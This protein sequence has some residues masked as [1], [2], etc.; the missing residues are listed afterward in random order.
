M[1][2]NVKL[3][4]IVLSTMDLGESDLLITLFTK[5]RGKI[6]AVAKGAKRSRKRFLNVLEPFGL[7]AGSFALPKSTK[8]LYRIDSADILQQFQAIGTDS[9]SYCLAGLACELIECWSKEEDKDYQLYLLL[10]ELLKALSQP[11]TPYPIILGFKVHLLKHAGYKLCLDQCVSC[12]KEV[13]GWTGFSIQKGGLICKECAG[14][15]ETIMPISKG[16]LKSLQ[17]LQRTEPA[18]FSRLSLTPKLLQELWQI[19]AQFH[20]YY[21]RKSPHSY[22]VMADFLNFEREQGVAKRS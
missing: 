17:F 9:E 19:L 14:N 3:T 20:I 21:L 4:G 5:E 15:R 8:T 2:N 6:K 18:Y 7:I 11:K 16:T 10:L 12:K 13:E 1:G 22:K